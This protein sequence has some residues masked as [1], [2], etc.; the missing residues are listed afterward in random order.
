[1]FNTAEFN[2]SETMKEIKNRDK[3][4][5]VVKMLDQVCSPWHDMILGT[6]DWVWL[7]H[8]TEKNDTTLFCFGKHGQRVNICRWV[9]TFSLSYTCIWGVVLF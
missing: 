5:L 3:Y 8:T 1:M 7:K 6:D 2:D 4:T 9:V